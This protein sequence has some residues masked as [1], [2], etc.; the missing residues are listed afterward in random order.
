MAL[1]PMVATTASSNL[2]SIDP[3]AI[4][5]EE[6]PG[7]KDPAFLLLLQKIKS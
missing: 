1:M 4:Q 7:S 5:I 6:R 2:I 3:Y